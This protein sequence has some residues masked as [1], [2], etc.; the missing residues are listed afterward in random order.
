V[1]EAIRKDLERKQQLLLE[2]A[3][4][5]IVVGVQTETGT[6]VKGNRVA[7]SDK[8]PDSDMQVV[9]IAIIHEY[10]CNIKLTPEGKAKSFIPAIGKRIRN[11]TQSII[12]P[13]RAWLRTAHSKTQKDVLTYMSANIHR[14][15]RTYEWTP[16]EYAE[17][18]GA[19]AVKLIVGALGQ[20]LKPLK[21]LT[22]ETKR[23]NGQ[24]D[25][26]LVASGQLQNHITYRVVKT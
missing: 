5:S 21:P 11:D 4:L 8:Y 17:H 14:V 10:G 20:G 22:I 19:F 16:M 23:L 13:E 26:I 1:F 24:S 12:I 6:N 18:C 3:A 9:D 2:L 7:G 15:L 25:A